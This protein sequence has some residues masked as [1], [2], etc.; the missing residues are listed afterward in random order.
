LLSIGTSL[1]ANYAYLRK[2]YPDC[3]ET[4]CGLLRDVVRWIAI[5]AVILL[6]IEFVMIPMNIGF[7]VNGGVVA[8]SGVSLMVNKFGPVLI[9]RLALAFLGAGIFAVL[10]YQTA[11]QPGREQKLG[12]L[13]YAAFVLVLVAEV[14]GRYLFYATQAQIGI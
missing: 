14:M 2:K 11:S 13:V 12:Y 3:A 4:Q 9:L 8:A 6:G 10:L 1:V 5:V 7:L